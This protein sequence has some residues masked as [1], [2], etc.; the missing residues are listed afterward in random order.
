[1][2]D[3]HKN[4][5]ESAEEI[6][7]FE[8][9]IREQDVASGGR[10]DKWLTT[11]LP[12]YSRTFLRKIFDEGLIQSSASLSLS[13]LPPLGTTL[14]IHIPPPVASDM[15]AENIPLT[16]LFE[17]EHL[18]VVDKPA[19]LVVH[20]APGNYSGTLVN[21]ILHHCPD[22]KSVGNVKR[23]GIVHRLDK[24]TSGV[25]VVAKDQATHEGL[26]LLFSKHDIVRQYWALTSHC[27]GVQAGTMEST[28]GRHPKDRL[29]MKANVTNGRKA[30]THF[31]V[32]E[33]FKS[34]GQHLE[35]TL[36]TGRTHQIRVHLTELLRR[37][38]A[39]DPLYGNPAQ[40][41]QKWTAFSKGL[42][43][44]PYPLLHAKVLGFVHPISKAK[45]HFDQN[46]PDLFLQTLQSLRGHK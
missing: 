46:P 12:Q 19:G 26:I 45:L 15:L 33:E 17:D 30:I 4:G 9:T 36:E 18:V 35:L 43:D 44:Y 7:D 29:K 42:V 16:I 14:S 5:N 25:M 21:A 11:Q 22:I 38:I 20:P 6:S 39:M 41:L 2:N 34:M 3:S 37:P 24:G 23:P 27:Q 8:I 40:D 1:M 31:K 10:L 28:I 13:K 32:L